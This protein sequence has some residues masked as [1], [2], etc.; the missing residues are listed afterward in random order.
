MKK[1]VGLFIVVALV[2]TAFVVGDAAANS[3]DKVI[4]IIDRIL[5]V[6]ADF[7]ERIF[8]S[9]ADAIKSIFTGDDGA[10]K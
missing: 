9:L 1:Y 8:Q 7:F 10:K 6:I 3:E 4:G 2:A 5:N